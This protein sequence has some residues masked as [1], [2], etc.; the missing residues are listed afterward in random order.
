M[1]EAPQI[2]RNSRDRESNCQPAYR[3]TSE[4]KDLLAQTHVEGRSDFDLNAA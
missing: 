3:V 1:M 4:N 2:C